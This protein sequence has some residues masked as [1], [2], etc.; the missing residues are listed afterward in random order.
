[1]KLLKRVVA[2]TMVNDELVDLFKALAHPIRIDIV[3][4]L[5]LA[6]LTT[7]ELSEKYKVSRYAI[8][9]HLTVLVE[10]NLILTRKKGKYRLNYLNTVPL[11]DLYNRWVSQ[12]D[13]PH[14]NSLLQLKNLVEGRE[15]SKMEQTKDLKLSSFQIE[16]EIT[17]QAKKETVFKALTE[18]ID[19]WWKF[20][21]GGEESKL[22]FEPRFAGLFYE[23]WGNGDG[24]VWGTV[25]F[26]KE[27]E[28]I[29]LNGLLGM[30]GS[31]NSSYG[32]KLI[33]N[34]DKTIIQLTH[35]A[36]GLLEPHWEEAHKHGWNELLG[37]HL[38]E[39]IEKMDVSK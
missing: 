28:E 22:Y 10:A 36:A 5:K 3:D 4:Q 30:K 25:T 19:K 32:Y 6:P 35:H 38:K 12:Y 39:F 29:R 2:Q 21:L 26:F 18:D 9:K 23:R 34:E 13:A 8:M 15:E 7:G 17:I 31:V 20:R 24:A 37:Q 16:Q 14:A 11:Q 1:V 27:N 33:G